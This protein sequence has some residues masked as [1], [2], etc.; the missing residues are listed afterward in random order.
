MLLGKFLYAVKIKN[1]QGYDEL[2][3]MAIRHA[4]A[5]HDTYGGILAGKRKVERIEGGS[6][7]QVVQKVRAWKGERE[8]YSGPFGKRHK[9]KNWGKVGK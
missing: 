5:D 3:E 8:S 4:Q 1:P 7:V 6:P 2:M 9:E